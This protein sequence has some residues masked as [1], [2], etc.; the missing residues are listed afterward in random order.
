M[1]KIILFGSIFLVANIANAQSYD[2][3]SPGGV[4]RVHFS[5]NK[6]GEAG[7]QVFFKN[8]EI[9]KPSSM[10]FELK[11]SYS[12]KKIPD[13]VNNFLV[14]NVDSVL[15]N[16]TWNPVWGEVKTIRNNYR[17]YIFHLTEKDDLQRKLDIVFR[18]F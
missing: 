16:E 2:L 11:E 14:S 15:M 1:K 10:G 4:V 5:L 13:L 17:Q 8:R 18:L 9:I 3:H 12:L 7:Y 6:K